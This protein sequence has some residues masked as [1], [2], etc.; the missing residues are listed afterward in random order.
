MP[1]TKLLHKKILN[2]GNAKCLGLRWRR[3]HRNRFYCQKH[4]SCWKIPYWVSFSRHRIGVC[5]K[6]SFW[7]FLSIGSAISFRVVHKHSLWR[8]QST[9][10]SRN[11]FSREAQFDTLKMIR[12]KLFWHSWVYCACRRTEYSPKVAEKRWFISLHFRGWTQTITTVLSI[13]FSRTFVTRVGVTHSKIF[14]LSVD[15]I[16]VDKVFAL[17]FNI[18]N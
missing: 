17:F 13:W 7:T 5:E 12:K 15:K 18:N 14:K 8:Y 11:Y 10:M 1:N 2:F 9:Q 3:K 16:A 4:N 6:N